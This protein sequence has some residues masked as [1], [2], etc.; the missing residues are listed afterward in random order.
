MDIEFVI[1]ES[2][3]GERL[4]QAITIMVAGVSRSSTAE[5][6]KSGIIRVSGQIR[7][8]GYR[9][10]P[11]DVVSGILPDPGIMVVEPQAIALDILFEDDHII[12]INK[13]P[14]LVVHPAP[15]NETGTLVNALLHRFPELKT[16]G[17][18]Q[19]RAGIVHRLD[20]DTSGVMVIARTDS[21][22]EFLQKE[23]KERRVSKRYLALATG[24]L[25]GDQGEIVLPIG[26]H[27]VHRKRMAVVTDGGRPAQTLWRL[28]KQFDNASL[29]EVELKTGRTHQIRVH[30]RA[31]GTPLLGDSVYGFKNRVN[32]RTNPAF[33][34]EKLVGRQMLHSWKLGFIHPWLAEQVHFRA[35]LPGDF[36]QILRRLNAH[37]QIP[38]D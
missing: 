22:F 28:R 5:A 2:L 27:P 13:A 7:K 36:R 26:R 8:P 9:V 6:V 23:F 10:K 31:M 25:G 20:K 18:T 1:S 30:F 14:G 16:V 24:D 38:R 35:P 37:G 33:H 4:D 3:T 11:G 29:V 17:E 21:S 12:I 34:L 32:S 19:F 15:G